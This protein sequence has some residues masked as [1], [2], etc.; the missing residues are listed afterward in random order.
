MIER[1]KPL[2]FHWRAV[3]ETWI[4]NLGLPKPRSRK[5]DEARRAV[6]VDAA[7]TGIAE[8]SRYISYSRRHDWWASGKRYRGSAFTSAT[9]PNAVDELTGEGLLDS[10]V[11]PPGSRGW[12]SR[13]CATS[14]LIAAARPA[15]VLPA[16]GAPT[17]IYDP[18]E[19]IRLKDADGNLIDYEDTRRTDAM[20][21]QMR[22][23]NE[24]LRATDVDLP[25]EGVSREGPF[26]RLG[27]AILNQAIDVMHR[28]FSRGSFALHGRAYGP[29]WQGVPKEA[30]KAPNR[31]RQGHSRA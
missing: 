27:D 25:A 31:Q 16:T 22:E 12:Q 5:H 18:G 8:P 2:S 4:D 20:R 7:L 1:D 13:F 19:L 11:A 24:A 17:V 3:D 23:I 26:L 28:V 9:V 15:L 14:A 29:W 30:E 10:Q 21:C 6:I